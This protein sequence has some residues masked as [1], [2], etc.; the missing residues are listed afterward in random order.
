M[1]NNWHV[2]TGGPSVGKT[3][4]LAELERRGHQTVPEAAR[5]VIDEGI[6]GGQTI[7]EIR[8][9]EKHFQHQVMQ[10]KIAIEAALKSDALTFFDRG[11]HDTISYLI[12]NGF[13]V[14]QWIHEAAS[15]VRYKT[16]FL[17]EPLQTYVQ[18]YARTE[19]RQEVELLTVALYK[20]YA[21]AGMQ[22]VRVPAMDVD[23]RSDY[24]LQRI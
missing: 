19:S 20:V 18:D 24:I 14:E 12:H 8:A 4:L 15:Q 21:D 13:S 16:V 10:R 23:K 5:L 6:A 17:L 7:Q 22:P 9:S 2:I 11:L 1:T 3:T